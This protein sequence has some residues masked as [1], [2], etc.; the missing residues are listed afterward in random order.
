MTEQETNTPEQQSPYRVVDRPRTRVDLDK[1]IASP[2]F[3]RGSQ[4]LADNFFNERSPVYEVLPRAP[5][6]SDFA[7]ERR[8][9]EEIEKRARD[10]GK[11]NP[12]D[13]MVEVLPDDPLE[14]ANLIMVVEARKKLLIDE[15][16][17][18]LV[19]KLRERMGKSDQEYVDKD[20]IT[21]PDYENITSEERVELFGEEVDP[22]ARRSLTAA[23]ILSS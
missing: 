7:Y 4:F 15:E 22:E 9:L 3:E 21:K 10:K 23:K 11:F 19:E 1:F 6:E 20:V 13:P 16:K 8:V 14:V 12:D 17:Q 5:E 18:A 2:E